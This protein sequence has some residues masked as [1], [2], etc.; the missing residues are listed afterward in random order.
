MPPKRSTEPF[1]TLALVGWLGFVMAAS[2]IAGFLLGL[3]LDRL[4]GT[5]PFLTVALL[6]VG[7]GGGMLAVYRVAMK[8]MET[9][10]D[11]KQ[12]NDFSRREPEQ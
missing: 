2:V 4:L 12:A 11:E 8:T 7:I 3:F 5:G 10:S 6:L 1:T 9:E